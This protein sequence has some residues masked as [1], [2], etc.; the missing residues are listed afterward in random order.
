MPEEQRG[1]ASAVKSIMELLPLVLLGFTIAPLVG[2][3][4]LNLGVLATGA[5]LLVTDAAD[6]GAGQRD[7]AEGEPDI[8]LA[9]SMLRVLG[10]LAGICPGRGG[11]PGCR[12][13]PWAGCAGWSPGRSP[14]AGGDNRWGSR[15]WRGGHGIVAVVAACG[16]ARWRP[17]A[18]RLRKPSFT[19]WVVNRLMFLAAITSIAGFCP[20]LP[21]VRLQG[22]RE[23]AASMTGTLMMVVGV[24]TLV[25]ALPGGWLADRIGQKRLVAVSGRLAVVGTLV[26]LF[27][28]WAPNLV[29]LYVAGGILGL[30]TG[31]FMT[32]NW[33]LGTRLVPA[34]EAGRYL[35][36]SNLAGAGAG[37]IGTGI[38]GPVADYLQR[39]PR[40]A[41]AIS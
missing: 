9:P 19:W 15:G 12:G 20:L 22:H 1:V 3:G 41:W 33:A 5:I 14:A 27:K 17:S 39:Q 35:G 30:A 13:V 10:M 6:D 24:F 16:R 38:G 26:V 28:I 18:S 32:T 4:R 23:A 40:P 7:A 36:I 29:L 11:R 8:P 2:A 25:S 21:D 37:M 34:A 31:L